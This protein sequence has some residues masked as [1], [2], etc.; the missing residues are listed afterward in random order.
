MMRVASLCAS[1]LIANKQRIAATG[2]YERQT[3]TGPKRGMSQQGLVRLGPAPRLT[4]SVLI[5]TEEV[6]AVLVEFGG[7][8][9]PASETAQKGQSSHEPR[10]NPTVNQRRSE[11]PPTCLPSKRRTNIDLAHSAVCAFKL[12]IASWLLIVCSLFVTFAVFWG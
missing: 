12:A 10:C 4:H 11:R 5:S 6:P 1:R 3:G 8:G 9:H 2:T 7:Y